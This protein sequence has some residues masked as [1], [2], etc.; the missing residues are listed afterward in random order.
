VRPAHD[1]GLLAIR[2]LTSTEP[3]HPHIVGL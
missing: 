2:A 3:R 1:S